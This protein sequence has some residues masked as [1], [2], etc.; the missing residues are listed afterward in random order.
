LV[1]PVR[2]GMNLVAK[3]FVASRVDG[4]G[5]LVLSEFAGAASEMAGALLVNPY[6]VQATAETIRSALSLSR[7]ERRERMLTL[8][9]RVTTADVTWWSGRF[10]SEL[11]VE[12]PAAIVREPSSQREVRALIER[13]RRA[14]K[15]VLLLD[16]D[17]TLVPFTPR[18]EQARPDE[19]LIALLGSL[20]AQPRLR[21][22]VVS[23]RPRSALEEYFG[24]LPIGLHSEHGLWSRDPVTRTWR[25]APAPE[26][27]HADRIAAILQHW[28]DRT[29]GSFVETK[30]SVLAWH[31]RGADPDVGRAQASEL[32][33]HLAELLANEAVEVVAGEHVIEVRPHGVN[34]G[35]VALG[36]L[37]DLPPDG[38]AVA[39]GDDRTDEDMFSV[40]GPP[41][42]TVG[43]GPRARNVTLRLPDPSAARAF[44]REIVQGVAADPSP[45]RKRSYGL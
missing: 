41:H 29:P 40:L 17:G 11:D 32:R 36:L 34:K 37:R 5:V 3:E 9:Q 33:L 1:T 19:E 25:R 31:W 27:R 42:A 13:V 44:L 20:A 28:A 22:E 15:V 38:L 24:D 45:I 4:D 43:V 18:P 39:L 23:G 16:Y 35:I 8:R 12:S 21:V 10:L 2:D 7:E 14:P 6:D 26:L 30:S